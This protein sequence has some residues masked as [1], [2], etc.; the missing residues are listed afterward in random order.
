MT[1]DNFIGGSG[2][3]LGEGDIPTIAKV[4]LVEKKK[5][6]QFLQLWLK[7]SLDVVKSE[8]GRDCTYLSF[9]KYNNLLFFK[10]YM[11]NEKGGKDRV[12]VQI[13]RAAIEDIQKK[14]F[15]EL[16]DILKNRKYTENVNDRST[17]T[18]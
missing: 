10:A 13:E 2:V 1:E 12:R 8:V 4:K 5:D 3:Q 7:Q 11:R 17:E 16:I 9:E 6:K 18:V 15:D 14:D